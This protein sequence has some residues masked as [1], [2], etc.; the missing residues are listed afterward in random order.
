MQR[1]TGSS[2]LVHPPRSANH[3]WLKCIWFLFSLKV[4]MTVRESSLNY[5]D[6][7]LPETVLLIPCCFFFFWGG[8]YQSTCEEL[9]YRRQELRWWSHPKSR[10]ELGACSQGWA[11]MPQ[12][13][14]HEV[15]QQRSRKAFPR[16]LA[17]CLVTLAHVPVELW[18]ALTQPVLK[19]SQ[20]TSLQVGIYCSPTS[21]SV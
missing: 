11:E 12:S 7:S 6:Y 18:L 4:A 1:E 10:V 2:L 15:G 20:C 19:E 17:A 21:L 13:L 14:L 16:R 8:T 5:S 9:F 3:S